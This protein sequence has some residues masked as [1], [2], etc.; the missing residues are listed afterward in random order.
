MIKRNS[1]TNSHE[2]KH[3]F[4]YA[5]KTHTTRI[6][7]L[8]STYHTSHPVITIKQIPCTSQTLPLSLPSLALYPTK[9]TYSLLHSTH[10]HEI[11]TPIWQ[12][13]RRAIQ[14]STTTMNSNILLKSYSFE[15]CHQTHLYEKLQSPLRT[16]YKTFINLPKHLALEVDQ[17][18][19]IELP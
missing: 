10:E 9:Q 11:Q 2:G 15:H 16:G 19:P 14:R 13:G 7:S 4:S 12:K 17:S 8:S 5:P 1:S 18:T 3:V 6:S